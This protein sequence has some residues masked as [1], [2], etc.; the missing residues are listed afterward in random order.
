MGLR[1]EERFDMTYKLNPG[2]E[3]IKS[4]TIV[5]IDDKEFVFNNGKEA[6]KQEYDRNYL[7]DSISAKD[8]TVIVVLKENKL[9]NSTN[10]MGEEQVSFF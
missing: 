2:I 9:I 3:K 5:V 1:C 6:V 10:W 8:D 4:K 7:V